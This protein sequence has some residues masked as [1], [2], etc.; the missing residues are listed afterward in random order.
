M[1]QIEFMLSTIDRAEQRKVAVENVVIAGWAGRDA[2]AVQAH[3]DELAELGVTPPPSVPCFYPVG[4][5]LVTV[6]AAV[7][8]LGSASS[9]EVE[10]FIYV[11]TDDAWWVGIGSDHTDREVEAYSV[12]VSKQVCPKPIAPELWRYSEIRETWDDLI[13]R[14]WIR[15]GDGESLYQEGSIASLLHPEDTVRAYEGLGGRMTPGT[16][17]FG[18]TIPV[19][20]G[21]R[22]A[23]EFRMEIFDPARDR[24]I[25][26]GYTARWLAS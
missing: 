22:P 2:E 17:M 20:G 6:G 19:L 15:E 24:R 3:I 12:G 11:D 9:G 26:H 14:S 25:T 1:P 21:I 13:L 5:E 10:Y 7:D 4:A 8:C 18:G 16:L 23:R